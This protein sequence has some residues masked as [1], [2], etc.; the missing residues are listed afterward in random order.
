MW[1]LAMLVVGE[2]KVEYV[3]DLFSEVWFKKTSR[4]LSNRE[5]PNLDFSYDTWDPQ[6][7]LS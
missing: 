6:R 5:H 3:N 7:M 2:N 1:M 4:Q